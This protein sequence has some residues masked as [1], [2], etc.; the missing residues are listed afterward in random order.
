MTRLWGKIRW[1]PAGA[2]FSLSALFL[3]GRGSADTTHS[4]G[5]RA[6][7][8]DGKSPEPDG[9]TEQGTAA[10]AAGGR[11]EPPPSPL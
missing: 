1:N 4:E 6:E 7:Q 8:Q 9:V 2:A 10:W 11:E 5:D 3:P